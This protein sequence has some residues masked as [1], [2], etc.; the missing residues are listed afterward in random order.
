MIAI[1]RK[2][3]GGSVKN[4]V[5]DHLNFEIVVAQAVNY[6][7]KRPISFQTALRDCITKMEVPEPITPEML[8]KGHSTTT[9]NII[10][11]KDAEAWQPSN[12]NNSK[13]LDHYEKLSAVRE[14]IAEI[15]HNEFIGTLL[16]QSTN[17]KN[18]YLPVS[19]TRLKTGDIVLI[20]EDMTKAIDYPLAIVLDTIENSLGETTEVR[21]RKAN[22]E[23]VRRHVSSVILFH[24]EKETRVAEENMAEK[25]VPITVKNKM[26]VRKAA[27]VSEQK[28]RKILKS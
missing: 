11:V 27:R 12:G 9:V 17:N 3:I 8:V 23:T 19:H 10:P 18:R 2:L 14:K 26:P 25:Y 20:Q 16:E 21:L 15:Y 28:T 7:N 4:Y 24:S 13:I 1:C 6:C 22:R 5:L